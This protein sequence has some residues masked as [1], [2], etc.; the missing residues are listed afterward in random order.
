MRYTGR[1]T[2]KMTKN[3]PF[4]DF[5]FIFQKLTEKD[6]FSSIEMSYTGRKRY[7]L[8]QKSMLAGNICYLRDVTKI[9][10]RKNMTTYRKHLCKVTM[11]SGKTDKLG[12]CNLHLTWFE[13]SQSLVQM[14][15]DT[16]LFVP[17]LNAIVSFANRI[18]SPLF[19]CITLFTSVNCVHPFLDICGLII[20]T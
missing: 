6:G 10:M 9:R 14:Q 7:D 17:V 19:H 5:D 20:C 11:T 2:F 16:Y 15:S 1:K 8:D 13:E 4:T 12:H 18:S 3:H